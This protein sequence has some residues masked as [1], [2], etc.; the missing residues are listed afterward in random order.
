VPPT[1]S[2]VMPLELPDAVTK[3][4]SLLLLTMMDTIMDSHAKS[5]KRTLALSVILRL[6]FEFAHTNLFILYRTLF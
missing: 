6:E 4:A 1:P 2:L 3:R 5:H